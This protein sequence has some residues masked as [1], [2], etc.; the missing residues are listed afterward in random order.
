MNGFESPAALWVLVAAQGL[1]ILTAFAARLTEGSRRQA[2]GQALFLSMLPLMGAATLVS[3]AVGPGCWV[4][5]ATTIAVMVL[6]VTWD[7]RR[8]SESAPW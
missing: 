2:I 5:C 6:T 1:G 3:L 4:G 8:G 7:F